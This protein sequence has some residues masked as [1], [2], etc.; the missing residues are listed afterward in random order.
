M[1]IAPPTRY[2]WENGYIH[3]ENG[4]KPPT[5]YICVLSYLNP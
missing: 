2:I 4:L 3:M 1:A 5:R